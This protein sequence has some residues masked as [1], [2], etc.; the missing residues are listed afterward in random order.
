M[1]EA[2]ASGYAVENAGPTQ[3]LI[4]VGLQPL[5]LRN[6]VLQKRD[7]ATQQCED[8]GSVTLNGDEVS[9]VAQFND[10]RQSGYYIDGSIE[11]RLFSYDADI[12]DIQMTFSHFTVRGPDGTLSTS[13][14]TTE[15]ILDANTYALT[16]A[17]MHYDDMTVESVS[18]GYTL[19]YRNYDV[20]ITQRNESEVGVRV[21]GSIKTSCSS[22]WVTLKTNQEVTVVN[23]RCPSSGR[24][25]ASGTGLNVD[26]TFQ[27]DGSVVVRDNANGTSNTYGSCTELANPSGC[28]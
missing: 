28:L 12:M 9:G 10:C 20:L 27:S 7:S 6:G 17:T 13:R 4:G 8:G 15:L 14:A 19:Q 25:N 2:M 24:V 26:V 16:S 22:K 23:G 1:L 3:T 11:Y 5:N 21:D 18:N